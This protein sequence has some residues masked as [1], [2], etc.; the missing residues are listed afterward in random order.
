M[1]TAEGHKGIAIPFLSSD[2]MYRQMIWDPDR[3]AKRLGDGFQGST[4]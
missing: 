4:D 1:G 3:V 2:Y